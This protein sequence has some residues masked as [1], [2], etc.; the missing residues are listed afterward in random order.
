MGHPIEIKTV[1]QELDVPDATIVECA[2]ARYH[3]GEL[4]DE[5]QV[6][7][8]YQMQAD[9]RLPL[10]VASL[11]TARGMANRRH[12]AAA[13]LAN[14]ITKTCACCTTPGDLDSCPFNAWLPSAG[15]N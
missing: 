5:R 12:I 15:Q 11:N 1:A 3:L 9:A 7:T 6:A 10:Q 4:A 8:L 13:H 14:K 2:A